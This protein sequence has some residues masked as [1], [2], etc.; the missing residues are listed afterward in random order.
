MF[1]NNNCGGY[2]EPENFELT[3]SDRKVLLK[4][5]EAVLEAK[6]ATIR[7]WIETIDEDDEEKKQRKPLGSRPAIG[8]TGEAFSVIDYNF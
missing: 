1:Y 4:E 5:R 7:H 6:L 8:G 2:C 3:K